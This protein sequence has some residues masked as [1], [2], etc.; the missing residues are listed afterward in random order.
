MNAERCAAILQAT[1]RH[2]ER[3]HEKMLFVDSDGVHEGRVNQE[4]DILYHALKYALPLVE[5]K[6]PK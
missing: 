1:I 4:N 2:H 3:M 5:E 6:I